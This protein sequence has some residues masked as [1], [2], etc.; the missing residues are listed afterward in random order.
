M[1]YSLPNGRTIQLTLDEYLSL[2]D[3][4]IQFLVAYNYGK[5]LN[6]YKHGSVLEKLSKEEID[7]ELE[8]LDEYSDEY[9]ELLSEEE[10][11]EDLDAPNDME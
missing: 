2:T 1:L 7:N 5:E 8:D 4:E 10:R 9:F 11:M 6:N 3:D